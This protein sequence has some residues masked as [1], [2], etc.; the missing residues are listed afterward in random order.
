MYS[1]RRST[2]KTSRFKNLPNP[3]KK[4]P[5]A[6]TIQEEEEEEG[7]STEG[8]SGVKW[9]SKD[10]WGSYKDNWESNKGH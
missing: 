9:G 7:R 6:E 8:Q 1:A 10:Q 4:L 5:D 2:S 3:K